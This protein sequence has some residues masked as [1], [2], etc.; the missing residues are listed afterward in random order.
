MFSVPFTGSPA[1]AGCRFCVWVLPCSLPQLPPACLLDSYTVS[2]DSAVLQIPATCLCRSFVLPAF[3]ELAPATAVRCR[4]LRLLPGF[5]SAAVWFCLPAH[6]TGLPFTC[7]VLDS[8][9]L[10]LQ[11]PACRLPAATGICGFI[12]APVSPHL[13]AT[14]CGFHLLYAWLVRSSPPAYLRF[15]SAV[16]WFTV[17]RS[18]ATCLLGSHGSFWFVWFS[19][20]LPPPLHLPGSAC[21]PA[22]ACGFCRW[23]L[24]TC[25]LPACQ[26]RS[27]SAPACLPAVYSAFC[28]PCLPPPAVATTSP[29]SPAVLLVGFAFWIRFTAY[30]FCGCLRTCCTLDY[31]TTVSGF[32]FCQ[33]PLPCRQF[34]FCLPAVH[35]STTFLLPP[36]LDSTWFAAAAAPRTFLRSAPGPPVPACF[37]AAVLDFY[38]WIP[39]RSL[40]PLLLP[41]ITY[42]SAFCVHTC[43]CC[44]V[45]DSLYCASRFRV[46]HRYHCRRSAAYLPLPLVHRSP[47]RFCL[48]PATDAR[49]CLVWITYRVS[50]VLPTL[51]AAV[52]ATAWF[53]Q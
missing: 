32:L 20:W 1:A 16:F 12:P 19:P 30:R 49:F 52:F 27:R 8:A 29:F 34:L 2:P 48:L 17:H 10:P 33:L 14:A 44:Q 42:T 50:A 11:L 53:C 46:L 15:G 7:R 51:P 24:P 6:H 37:T 21:L 26:L 36:Y 38:R 5:G 39:F 45:T 9:V 13:P 3:A 31:R 23:I 40:L 4:H 35:H 41:A 47:V 25:C 18:A 28:I 43:G 22:P